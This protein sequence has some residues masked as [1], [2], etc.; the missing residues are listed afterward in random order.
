MNKIAQF[1][2][3]SFEQFFKDWCKNFS[4]GKPEWSEAEVREIYDGITL[5]KRS[6]SGS[7]GY[8]FFAP[9][10]ICIPYKEARVIPTGIRCRI[11]EGWFLDINPRSG[12]GFKYGIRLANTRGIIDSD[13]FNADNEGHIMI[14]LV[15]ES[16]IA[17]ENAAKSYID[18]NVL[19]EV[20][21]GKAFC[22]GIF[23]VYGITVDDEADNERT[24]GFGSTGM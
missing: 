23:T 8:D 16:Y 12:Q 21:Q 10:D 9:A 17:T 24:G 7:A 11:D 22:Q 2:K 3:V 14:K 5:P 1:Y 15:N 4:T 6:T 20:T 13:Y 19:F 18:E